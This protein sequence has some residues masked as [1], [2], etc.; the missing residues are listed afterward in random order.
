M[1]IAPTPETT[2]DT[3]LTDEYIAQLRADFNSH[4]TAQLMQ[5]AV[6][7]NSIDL[8]SR[9]HSVVATTDH[10]FSNLLDSWKVTNQKQSGRCWLFAGLNLF[11]PAAMAALNLKAFEFSQNYTLFW[12][13]FERA[14]YFLEAMI[15]TADREID[16][17]TVAFLL[18]R[19]LDDGGQWNMF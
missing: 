1:A 19:P 3:R 2:T 18:E 5:N 6:T 16:D 14:N 17:R 15:E 4:P 12:D 10:S 8:V 9:N 13:K 7:S 11:R